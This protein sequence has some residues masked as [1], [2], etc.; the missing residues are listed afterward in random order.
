MSLALGV[1]LA[2]ARDRTAIVAVRSWMTEP[3][4]DQAVRARRPRRERHHSI[5]HAE[6]LRVGV[7]YPEQAA[8]IISI[9]EGLAGDERPTLVVDATGVGRAVVDMIRRDSP[10]PV[11]AVTIGAGL[12]VVRDGWRVTVPKVEL[13]G[14]LEVV[15]SS[16]RIHAVEGLPLAK[17]IADELRSFGYEM[18]ATGRPK[19]E[20][21]G[22]HDDLVMALALAVWQGERGGGAGATFREF[23]RKDT[24]RTGLENE[25]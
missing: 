3:T 25:R 7:S 17:D 20:G 14:A 18:S 13:V 12:E 8:A 22:R 11:R 15:L 9:A 19:Y 1:D 24:A 16:R 5:D 10:F 4:A 21:R 23:M 2:Q 6:R